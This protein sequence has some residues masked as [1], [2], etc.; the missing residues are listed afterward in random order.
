MSKDKSEIFQMIAIIVLL[1]CLI[2]F[3][4]NLIIKGAGAFLEGIIP[5]GL[6]FLLFF[7]GYRVIK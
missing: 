4:D 5:V 3:W 6:A 1:I 2:I 7:W